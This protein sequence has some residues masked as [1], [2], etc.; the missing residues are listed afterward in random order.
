ME[1]RRVS[2]GAEVVPN[3]THF[4]VF[5]P[6]RQRVDVVFDGGSTLEL[7][8]LVREETGFFSGLAAGVKAGARYKLKLDG[9]RDF[10]DPASRFQ[11]EGPH[12]WSEV[13]DPTAFRWTDASWK[14]CKLQ[15]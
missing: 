10:P 14:G 13:I 5:A 11:P 4:R 9:E 7:V 1:T 8:Q 6:R 2:Q 12:G 3:G 15:G